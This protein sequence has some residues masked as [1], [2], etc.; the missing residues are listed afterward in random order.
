MIGLASAEYLLS[1]HRYQ[2]GLNS[3][4]RV[5]LEVAAPPS[6]NNA[7]EVVRLYRERRDRTSRWKRHTA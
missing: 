3:L 6:R 1:T 4:V 2:C 7:T 5:T